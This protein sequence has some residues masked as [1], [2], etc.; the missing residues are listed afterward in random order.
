MARRRVRPSKPLKRTTGTRKPAP[1][2]KVF[3][4][5]KTEKLYLESLARH[6]RRTGVSVTIVGQ[7]GVPS[8]IARK[9]RDATRELEAKARRARGGFADN[10][11][12]WAVFDR[13]EH[14]CFDA[15]IQQCKANQIGLAWSNPCV[16][17]WALLH[18][19]DQ[20]A[21]IHR[22]S[23][24]RELSS[25][26]PGY[27]HD[28]GATFV[29]EQMTDTARAQARRRA[30]VLHRR[31]DDAQCETQ[32][33]TTALWKLVDVLLTGNATQA[34]LKAHSDGSARYWLPSDPGKDPDRE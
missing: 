11:E 18:F 6:L 13:D 8:T 9:A 4:E 20:T 7:Q 28:K 34:R 30:I 26:M 16:E 15:A 3:C 2:I 17:L 21:W 14:H 5:G 1:V 25:V 33:P 23:C 31:A 12:V 10:F 27:D 19:R 29:V 32:N 24:Q 22:A